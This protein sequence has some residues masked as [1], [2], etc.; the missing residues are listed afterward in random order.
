MISDLILLDRWCDKKRKL[1]NEGEETW[2]LCF[3]YER[4]HE[5]FIEH[6]PQALAPSS[7]CKVYTKNIT[8]IQVMI[9]YIPKSEL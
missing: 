9:I 4:F 6:I 3:T 5:I 7:L 8:W 2:I 1:L